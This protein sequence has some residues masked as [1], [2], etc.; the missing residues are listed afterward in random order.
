MTHHGNAA[1]KW[2]MTF[3]GL[4]TRPNTANRRAPIRYVLSRIRR[5]SEVLTDGYMRWDLINLLGA[6]R[7]HSPITLDGKKVF[8][9]Y[10]L[11]SLLCFTSGTPY[12]STKASSSLLESC[13]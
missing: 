6:Q 4:W 9:P 2:L 10:L 1:A 13:P 5:G 8:S 7:L 11:D 3:L 12:R